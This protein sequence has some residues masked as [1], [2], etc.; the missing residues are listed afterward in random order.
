MSEIW[1]LSATRTP[2]G[3][4]GGSLA[5]QTAVQI[6]VVAVQAAIQKAGLSPAQIEMTVVG[7]ARQAG[8]GPNPGR[9]ISVKSGIPVTS[10]AY[11]L[12]QACASGLSAVLAAARHIAAGEAEVV[13]AAGSES[14]S[15]VPYLAQGV[16]W[17]TKMGHRPLV[18]AMYQDGL[19]CP[20]CD[21]IM[22]ET[23]EA[24]AGELSISRQEQDEYALQSQQ[25]AAAADFSAELCT[26]AGLDH[27]EHA[28]SSTTLE[29]LGKLPPVFS[30]TGSVTAGNAS[31]ITDGA[32]ALVVASDAFVKKHQLKP[33]ARYLG[34]VVVGLE[35][36]RMGLGPV[37]AIS[38]YR[39]KFG[40]DFQRYE[41]NE[42]FAAQVLACQREL[43]LDPESL[44]MKG[45]S[46]AIGH[47]IG[48][49]GA[50]IATTLI[51]G[52]HERGGGRG[53]ASLCVS[54]GLGICAGF[55]V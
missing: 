43:K 55:E 35:P 25:R 33:I 19:L 51:H 26:I 31:G 28:R 5:S 9:Q 47:P 3:R 44:N 34:G 37:P 12:N 11:T 14:M 46:I 29:S 22:G 52:L 27:D 49:S 48:C 21:K 1:I 30:K 8:C 50:R 36:A 40:G 38:A 39:Q 4:F 18:D 7:L 54:G 10:P 6:G 13:V 24:L 45:G 20:L 16:R 23:V 41:I 53:L 17:G 42:A 32:A 2:I 15:N